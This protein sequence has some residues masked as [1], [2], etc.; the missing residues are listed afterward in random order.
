MHFLTILHVDDFPYLTLIRR[1]AII[2]DLQE[3]I[4]AKVPGSDSG[5]VLYAYFRHDTQSS[6]TIAVVLCSLLYQAIKRRRGFSEETKKLYERYS[7]GRRLAPAY[8]LTSKALIAELSA[9]KVAYIVV[10]ALDEYCVKDSS[11]SYPLVT[12]L[13]RLNAKLLITSRPHIKLDRHAFWT[14]RVSAHAD[15]I[16]SF[17]ENH[18]EQ[19]I[20]DVIMRSYGLLEE[21]VE[22]VIAK[23]EGM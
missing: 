12:Q 13:L 14:L 7:Q 1:P 5:V 19:G 11:L 18:T 23:S 16:R 21:I 4:F 9:F 10:D 2:E 15:D 17:V 8:D 20:S 22:A 6:Q 3:R